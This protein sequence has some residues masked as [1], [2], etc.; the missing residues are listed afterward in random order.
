M[1]DLSVERT[2]VGP[3]R[4]TRK[5]PLFDDEDEEA[6]THSHD[7]HAALTLDKL[8]TMIRRSRTQPVLVDDNCLKAAM[9]QLGVTAAPLVEDGGWSREKLQELRKELTMHH[10]GS[11]IN[12]ISGDGN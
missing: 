1:A 4:T 12:A 3:Q 6:P 9:L 7:S 5:R 11:W 10:A 2:N 8:E